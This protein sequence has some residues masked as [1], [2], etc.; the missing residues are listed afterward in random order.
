VQA[1]GQGERFFIRMIV[2]A[3]MIFAARFAEIRRGGAEDSQ[4]HPP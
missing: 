2:P 1:T 3:T 4:A